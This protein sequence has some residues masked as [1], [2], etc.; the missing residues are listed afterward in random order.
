MLGD[1]VSR[2][3]VADLNG[4]ARPD[5]IAVCST[6]GKIHVLTA[7]K[8]WSF[9]PAQILTFAGAVADAA[10]GLEVGEDPLDH[11]AGEEAISR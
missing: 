10:V 11:T 2:L 4:D 7:E 5:L 8:A 6:T 1:P 3:L 9:A